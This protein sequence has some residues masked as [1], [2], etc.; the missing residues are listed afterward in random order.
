[1][2]NEKWKQTHPYFNSHMY[3]KWAYPVSTAMAT[4]TTIDAAHLENRRLG[5][6]I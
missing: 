1:M 2:Q 3:S 6:Q 5:V 4:G